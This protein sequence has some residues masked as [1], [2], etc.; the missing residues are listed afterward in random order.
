MSRIL[1]KVRPK[2]A[3]RRAEGGAGREVDWGA[4]TDGSTGDPQHVYVLYD[5]IY[6][7]NVDIP[8]RARETLFTLVGDPQHH[9]YSE[10]VFRCQGVS[11]HKY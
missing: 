6:V 2:R 4:S 3:A 10:V 9:V 7:K 8:G 11:S 1:L 5:P